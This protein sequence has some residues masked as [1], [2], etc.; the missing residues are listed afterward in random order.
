MTCLNV[1][2]H[3]D[4]KFGGIAVAV[5]ALAEAVEQDGRYVN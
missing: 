2:D 3:C 1:F 4:V 5:P